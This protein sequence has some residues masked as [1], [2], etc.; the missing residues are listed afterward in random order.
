MEKLRPHFAFNGRANRQRY[1]LTSLALS[2][3][4]LVSGLVAMLVPVIGAI[5][6]FV[7]FI[8]AL[9]A[10]L[11]IS[12]RRLHDRDKSAWWLVAMYLPLAL[13]SAFAG[14]V[15]VTDPDVGNAVN[16]LSL[17]FT[18]WAFI[19]LGC[20]KGTTGPNRFGAD[21]LQPAY[22]VFA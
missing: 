8:G 13:I 9:W 20:L 3:I 21:P 7:G 14:A 12:A 5:L 11:A 18:L 6:M 10:A 2:G 1:W 4:M 22:E 17:P 16:I 15:S 19:E